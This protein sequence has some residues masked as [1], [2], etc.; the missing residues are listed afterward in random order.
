[1]LAPLSFHLIPQHLLPSSSPNLAHS[2]LA[3]G[4]DA[5]CSYHLV[6]LPSFSTRL[7][8][9]HFS[10]LSP[11]IASRKPSLPPPGF[12]IIPM[13]P[14]GLPQ[15]LVIFWGA[16]TTTGIACAMVPSV[17][18]V[19]SQGLVQA[20][21]HLLDERVKSMGLFSTVTEN[22]CPAG[23]G[24]A[25]KSTVT[26]LLLHKFSSQSRGSCPRG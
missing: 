6:S 23:A 13:S 9:L 21:K 5:C 25:R 24:S 12:L 15:H 17:P 8:S 26:P 11:H 7:T 18:T 3:P 16:V 1:M 10:N 2:V 20:G 4:L 22:T 19:L 14:S